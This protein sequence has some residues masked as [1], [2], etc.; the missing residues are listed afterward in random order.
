MRTLFSVIVVDEFEDVGNNDENITNS[1]WKLVSRLSVHWPEHTL[2]VLVVRKFDLEYGPQLSSWSWITDPA[3]II[4]VGLNC[5]VYTEAAP[6]TVELLVN[7]QGI[8]ALAIC[9]SSRLI[10]IIEDEVLLIK[11]NSIVD[12]PEYLDVAVLKLISIVEKVVDIV[13][14]FIEI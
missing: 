7:V 13:M 10:V 14:L 9:T 5:T 2:V 8:Y 3:S 1:T 11:S 4:T 12:V 6:T